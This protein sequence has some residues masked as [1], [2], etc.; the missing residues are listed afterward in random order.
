MVISTHPKTLC[1]ALILSLPQ[2][3]QAAPL[4][5]IGDNT[6][7]YFNGSTSLEW[8]SNIFRDENGEVDDLLWRLVPGF[9]INFGRGVSNFDMSLVARNE[10]RRYDSESQSDTEL[11]DARI[12][13]SYQASRLD[14]GGFAS[15]R[16]QKSNTS[17]SNLIGDLV[18]SD[19]F[20]GRLE[21]EYRLSPK[22][23]FGAAVAYSD[24]E[25]ESPYSAF[26]AD[27]ERYTYPVDLFYEL[28]PKVDL[29]VGYT[30]AKTEVGAI[31]PDGVGLAVSAYDQMSH[32]FSLGAR[33]DLLPKLTGFF[34]VGYR[35]SDNDDRTERRPDRDGD[36]N[37]VR[38]GDGNVVIVSRTVAGRD[39]GS[40]GLDADLTWA[41]SPKLT[42]RLGA[43][44]DFGTGGEGQST[45]QTSVNGSVNYSLNS[46]LSA[47]AFASYRLS[48][49]DGGGDREDE[50]HS[51]GARLS[52]AA[53][54]FWSFGTGYSMNDNESTRA[55]SSYTVHVFDVTA[56]L[57]Y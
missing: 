36:G 37:L 12:Q 22:F 15:F 31:E 55:N 11:F 13:G 50:Q 45:Q 18:E 25:Y 34:K 8:S 4:V 3:L 21:A 27:Q 51:L 29:S 1:L 20:A 30:H 16:E 47:T 44:R 40:L 17:N 23:S 48:E 7:I 10:I 53:N 41:L 14:L 35:V 52:Y 38:D 46:K 56:R 54:E 57:R 2:F 26:V 9:E 43:S 32:F 28:T 5:S 49:Y 24:L 33:G 42:T 6:D 19:V 39:N